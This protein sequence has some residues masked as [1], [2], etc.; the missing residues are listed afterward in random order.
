[1]LKTG[2]VEVRVGNLDDVE[3]QPT[4]HQNPPGPLPAQYLYFSTANTDPAITL[5]R[6]QIPTPRTP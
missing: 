4:Q 6:T 5:P 1:M 3:R 2:G